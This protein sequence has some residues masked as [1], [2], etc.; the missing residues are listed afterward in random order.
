MSLE[1]N[2]PFNFTIVTGQESLTVKLL[3]QM[4]HLSSPRSIG[5]ITISLK[6]L[7]D[8]QKHEEWI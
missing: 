1:W 8:Q 6:A 7:E 4:A 3:T 5:T 2:E